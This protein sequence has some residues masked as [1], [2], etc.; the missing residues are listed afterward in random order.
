MAI[1]IKTHRAGMTEVLTSDGATGFVDQQVQRV[2]TTAKG[3]HAAQGYKGDTI[4]GK[5]SKPRAHGMVRTTD[6][7]A[8]RS[9][10]K[11]NTLLKALGGGGG[12]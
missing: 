4:R 1:R 7:H 11:Y 2:V 5:G 10:A 8:A 6:Q 3:M 12:A 9:N